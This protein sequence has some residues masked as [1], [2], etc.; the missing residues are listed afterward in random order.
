MKKLLLTTGA[1]VVL[2]IFLFGMNTLTKNTSNK[3]NSAVAKNLS[4]TNE[5]A[6][7]ALVE[8]FTSEG[9]SSCPPADEL[10]NKLAKENKQN[11]F[12]LSYHVDY[13]NKLGWKDKFSKAEFT[14]RQQQYAAYFNKEGVYTPQIVVNGKT[15]F[16]GSDEKK[17]YS[18][19]NNAVNAVYK[20][21]I[22]I[23][24]TARNNEIAV[25][26]KVDDNE[27][28]ALNIALVQLSGSSQVA[29]GENEGRLLQHTNIVTDI[30]KTIAGA[31]KKEIVFTVPP[32]KDFIAA[33]YKVVAFLQNDDGKVIAAADRTIK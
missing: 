32:A 31:T 5:A 26:Y 12:I 4:V 18:T 11:V 15:E 19:I 29:N 3:K 22:Q 21:P 1:A 7:F 27:K 14:N 8:L 9:C 30:K 23:T 25:S 2:F 17:L 28:A 33:D 13:W 16:V 24:A 6:G 20:S 10:V